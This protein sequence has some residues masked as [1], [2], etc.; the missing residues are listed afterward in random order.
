[1]C[2]MFCLCGKPAS[3][4]GSLCLALGPGLTPSTMLSSNV[5]SHISWHHQDKMWSL[6]D[7]TSGSWWP[8]DLD[9][10]DTLA[11]LSPCHGQNI[12]QFIH[13]VFTEND[14]GLGLSRAPGVRPSPSSEAFTGDRFQLWSHKGPEPS[15]RASYWQTSLVSSL[16]FPFFC[17]LTQDWGWC[18]MCV[19]VA[20]SS[21]DVS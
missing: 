1:M 9:S 16:T 11:G 2:V 7:E 8:C 13:S 15:Q 3:P 18:C 12:F 10:F 4:A 21:W 19:H 5:D 6:S 14:H 17:V 20:K